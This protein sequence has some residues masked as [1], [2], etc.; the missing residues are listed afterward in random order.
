[1]GSRDSSLVDYVL[2]S[3]DLFQYV[4]KFEVEDPNIISDH[5]LISFCFDFG[6]E[7]LQYSLPE[8]YEYVD[9][10]FIWKSEFRDEYVTRLYDAVTLE[11]LNS[12]NANISSCTDDSEVKSCL[13]DFVSIFHTVRFPI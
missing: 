13:N 10:K 4:S 11:K 6:S 1:M 12:L 2:A 5:Y 9:G 8:N 7:E 3:Q